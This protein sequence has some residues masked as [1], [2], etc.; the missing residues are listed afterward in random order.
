MIAPAGDT[1]SLLRAALT[2]RYDVEREI[3][4]GGMAVVFLARDL[5]HERPVAIKVL[6]P[7]L[8]AALGPERFEREIRIA[9]G[10]Q[11]PGILPVYDSGSSGELLYYV[12]PFVEGESLRDFLL[13]SKQLPVAEAIR[14]TCEVADALGHA[15]SHGIVHRDIKPENILLESGHAL[16]ADFGIARALQKADREQLTSSGIV[17]GTPAYMS[18]EQA[19]G[20][21][22]LDGRSD[23]YSLGCVLYEML[24]G[25]P[26]FTGPTAQAV[27]AKHAAERPPSLRIVRPTIP[28]GLQNVVNTA[29]AKVPA[30][31]FATATEFAAA[32][33]SESPRSAFTTVGRRRRRIVRIVGGSLAAVALA[34]VV[35]LAV[36]RRVGV[37]GGADPTRVAVLFF[38]DASSTGGLAAIADALTGKVIDALGGVEQLD[39]RPPSAVRRFRGGDAPLD[40][41][42]D[43]LRVGSLVEGTVDSGGGLLRATA[44]VVDGATLRQLASHSVERAG[45]APRVLGELAEEL[46]AFV[47]RTIGEQVQE[48]RDL[49]SHSPSAVVLVRRAVSARADAEALYELGDPGAVFAK[50]AEADSLLAHAQ[51]E[52]RGWVRPVELRGWVAR[53]N[54]NLASYVATLPP[55]RRPRGQQYASEEAYLRAALRFADR[56]VEMAPDDAGPLELRGWIWLELANYPDTPSGALQNAERDLR[57]AVAKDERR[58]RAWHYLSLA[59][60]MRGKFGEAVVAASHALRT[61]AFLEEAPAVLDMLLF[62]SL[63]LGWADSAAHWCQEG[64]RRFPSDVRFRQCRLTILGWYGRTPADVRAAWD[65]LRAVEVGDTLGHLAQ[66]AGYRRMMV[67][68]VLARSGVR[69]SASAVV[70]EGWRVATELE[71]RSGLGLY[72]AY[73]R[74][75]TGETDSAFAL[76]GQLVARD[77]HIGEFII[78]SP[79][80]RPLHADP[81]FDVL[82]RQVGGGPPRS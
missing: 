41:I 52:D 40:T 9:A 71:I 79:W 60:E 73:V 68:A 30:D 38:R 17:M 72:E 75:L 20:D 58:A 45:V 26:P 46:A 31:R 21:G 49:A 39:V 55:E 18:P 51:S 13:R 10:L 43:A 70:A 54:A 62:A 35:W 82:V 23:I 78:H 65:E 6:R 19:G 57:L 77:A 16:V 3:G 1:L 63:E 53:E 34:T 25:E 50:L 76:L 64:T 24:A 33:E 59:L 37:G 32:L 42:L 5:R 22:Q 8:S 80:F 48:R 11:H 28:V 7:E 56:A 27:L 4:R 47:R 12:M 74:T 36:G 2:G 66:T 61:D 14:I 67:A 69:D 15:H 81:R 29:L 44:R